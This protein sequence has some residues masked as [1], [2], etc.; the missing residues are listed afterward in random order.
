MSKKLIVSKVSVQYILFIRFTV[1]GF[2][3]SD[4]FFVI[5]TFYNS[6]FLIQGHF[7]KKL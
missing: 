2:I 4:F 6:E 7:L 3:I 5:K 1:F